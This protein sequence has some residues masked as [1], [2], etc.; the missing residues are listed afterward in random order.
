MRKNKNYHLEKY[1]FEQV[2]EKTM[3]ATSTYCGK[4]VWATAKCDPRDN[5]SEEDGKKLAAARCNVK[6]A[7]KRRARAKSKVNEAMMV[8]EIVYEDFLKA[9]RYADDAQRAYDKAKGEAD[10][11]AK[12]M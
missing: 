8:L 5:F 7:D 4:E 11:L 12:R 6:I 3:K 2:D 9:K 10:R 1:K